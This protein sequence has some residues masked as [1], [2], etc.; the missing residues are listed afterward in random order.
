MVRQKEKR[1][2]CC[3]KISETTRAQRWGMQIKMNYYEGKEN[4][5]EV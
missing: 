5:A 1:A 3:L 4:N 2:T